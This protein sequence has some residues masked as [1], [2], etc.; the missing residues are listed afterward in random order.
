VGESPFSI[1]RPA[2]EDPL[3]EATT[4]TIYPEAAV[5]DQ[6]AEPKPT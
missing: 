5:E 1:P 6:L 2:V 4:Y 3:A